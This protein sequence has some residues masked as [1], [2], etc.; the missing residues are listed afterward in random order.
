MTSRRTNRA[1]DLQR[2]RLAV[3]SH[4]KKHENSDIVFTS[5]NDTSHKISYCVDGM[6]NIYGRHNNN[7]SPSLKKN[8]FFMLLKYTFVDLLVSLLVPALAIDSFTHFLFFFFN[9]LIN[10]WWQRDITPAFSSKPWGFEHVRCFC[11]EFVHSLVFVWALCRCSCSSTVQKTPIF[12]DI[13]ASAKDWEKKRH[14][15]ARKTSIWGL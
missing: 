10:V 13:W 2:G 7:L 8:A 6:I 12:L 11:V 14:R 1:I 4:W 5:S 3:M 15:I 9:E